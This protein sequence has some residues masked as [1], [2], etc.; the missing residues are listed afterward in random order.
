[1]P[2][3]ATLTLS[4]EW[5]RDAL[6]ELEEGAEGPEVLLTLDEVAEAVGRAVSTV[7]T[8]C[9]SGQ[10]EGAFRLNGRDWRVPESAL[11]R[12]VESQGQDGDEDEIGVRAGEVDLGRWRRHRRAG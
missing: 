10:I 1:M 5:L 11:R 6:Q 3:G 9:N 12:Y 4:V 8:W 2:E 7:R